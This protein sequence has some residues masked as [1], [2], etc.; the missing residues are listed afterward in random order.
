MFSV[1]L[2]KAPATLPIG[3]EALLDEALCHLRSLR[4]HLSSLPR[5]AAKDEEEANSTARLAN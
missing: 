4:R 5:G 2:V 3:W 1:R